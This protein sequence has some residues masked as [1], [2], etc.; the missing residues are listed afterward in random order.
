MKLDLN[1]NYKDLDG[2]DISEA[3]MG[4][5]LASLLCGKSGN[6]EPVKA[7]DWALELHKNKSIEI[8]KAD[9]MKLTKF[10]ESS[11]TMTN[12]AKA[13]LLKVCDIKE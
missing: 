4:K 10:I 8:D 12:L 6:I 5:Q 9:L 7:F 13:Q 2:N 11:E 1:L 3:N